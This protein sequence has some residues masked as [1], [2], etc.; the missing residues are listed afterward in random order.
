MG[1]LSNDLHYS[2]R[3]L[4]K[5]PG[6]TLI[7]VLSLALGIGVN[8]TVFSVAEAALLRSWPAR[9]P[10][11][12][13]KIV[14]RSPQGVDAY[15]SYPDYQDL[16]QQSRAFDGILAW[17]RHSKSLRVGT[18]TRTLLDDLVSPNYFTTLGLKAGR[19][20]T[21][22]PAEQ[23]STALMVVVSDDLWRHSFGADPAL[24]GKQIVLTNR[25]YTVIGIAPPKFRG[26]ERGV[27]TD[28]WLTATTEISDETGDRS[29]RD[30]EL[31]GRLRTGATAVQAQA[32]LD[33]I[34]H[35]LADAYPAFDKARSATL[36]SEQE[37]L[38]Q[39]AFPAFLL[40]AAVALVLLISS[41]NV[42]GLVLARSETRRREIAVRLALGAGRARLIRQLLTENAMLAVAGAALGL[43]LTRWLF[44]LQPAF[45][46]PMNIDVGL[47]LRL[48]APVI[49]FTLAVSALAVLIFGLAP[50]LGTTKT[51]LSPAL[52]SGAEGAS[53][54][55]RRLTL[56][57][58][59]VL[60]EVALS[61]VLLTASGLLL[62]SLLYSRGI[63]LGFDAGRNLVFFEVEPGTA[64][65]NL[66]R[67]LA[68]FDRLRD[69]VA[70]LPGVRH[71]TYARRMLLTDSGGGA[72]QR[73]S[74][75]GV[76]L[77]QGQ[78]N[79]PIKFNAVGPG[80][81]RTVGTRILEGRDFTTTDSA[82]GTKVVLISQ[83]MARRFWPGQNAV[84]RHIVAEGKDC[85]IAGVVE[86][87]KINDVHEAPEPYIYFPFG[88]SAT[89]WGTLIVETAGDPRVLTD[90]IRSAIRREDQNVP[91]GVFTL[92][93]LM[94]EA[95]WSDQMAA[96]FVGGLSALGIFLASV[97]L[98][99][100]IAY[101]VNRRRREIGIRMALGAERHDVLRLVLA[102]GLRLAAIGTATGV[103][104]AWA[105]TRLMSNLLY[106]VKPTDP[107]S[108]AASALIAIVVALT[109]SYVPAL[110]ASRV[111]PNVALR[112][113]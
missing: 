87:A 32:E 71:V 46:P 7:A 65:Y 19:G 102:Q 20:R 39:A 54:A 98:Y 101:V 49:L 33:T 66:E 21:F 95:Y 59:L 28:L 81:L 61:V 57:N 108:F 43:V 70:G 26:L 14:A 63:H 85:Q 47:D 110:R 88:Q 75:P 15:F 112:Y 31:L 91:V 96:G 94:Q 3:T 64:G 111:E 5:D 105:V 16:G 92:H 97:G 62:R 4:V 80:Y 8:S 103:A 44:R 55:V 17:S 86:D 104:A 1:A 53:G 51:N 50:A 77:P 6:F 72:E 24:V 12:L 68:Y 100:V 34:S 40:M 52:K 2:L 69:N 106:G 36:I 56:R 13:A 10:E 25:N 89:D 73:V 23:S 58:G 74:L 84:G 11:R 37:R 35:R 113:E 9:A 42:A 41:A 30:F 67:S 83:T 48:D 60:A 27:P 76:V 90:T 99:G 82:A 107:L 45:F 93:F 18:D 38:R 79:I 22:S 78:P 109:A 29:V